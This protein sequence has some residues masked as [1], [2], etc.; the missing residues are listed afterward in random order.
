MATIKDVAKRANVSI[1]TVSHVINGTK[2]VSA[3]T[4]LRV[5]KAINEL[6]YKTNV[7]ARNLKNQSTRQIGVIVVDMCGL[8]FPYVIKEICHIANENHY[9][10]TI[11]DSKGDIELEK[12]AIAALVENCV[13][14]IIL[15]SAVSTQDKE[16]YSAELL[17]MLNSGSRPIPLVMLERDFTA[18]GLD[19]ICTD[20]YS[21]AMMAMNHLISLGSRHIA[22]IAVPCDPEGRY[23]AYRTTLEE[24]NIPFNKL[25]ME[26]GDYTH[27]S[28]YSC[29]QKILSRGLPLDSVFVGN[30]QMAVGAIRALHE[31]GLRIPD[32]VKVIGFDNVF[33]CD[34]LNPPLSSVHIEKVL[35]GKQGVN[36]LLDRI[37][38][39]TSPRPYKEVIESYL[40]VRDSTLKHSSLHPAIVIQDSMP[41]VLD[42]CK[43]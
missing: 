22:H 38:N 13:D 42:K 4:A 26:R 2:K 6:H 9:T 24:N 30:D 25:Y 36:L 20:T 7:F 19:S 41:T 18:Y 39:G 27:E 31:A 40:V 33:I 15:S 10:V 5:E 32:D 12:A 28:G 3:D 16:T 11:Y 29:M 21:G 23:F 43:S 14:G 34:S 1:S 35:L 37:R 17:S 8:F